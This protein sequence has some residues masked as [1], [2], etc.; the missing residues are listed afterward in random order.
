MKT[1]GWMLLAVL[2]LFSCKRENDKPSGNVK[3][4]I[5]SVW[6]NG[7][8]VT[9]YST[10]YEMDYEGLELRV[11]F[12]SKVDS[13]LFN[14]SKFYFSGE[15]DTLYAYRFLNSC[16]GLVISTQQSL[17]PLYSYR[18]SIEEGKNFGG[19][20]YDPFTCNIVTRLDT[21]PKF[22]SISEDSLLTLV[23]EKTFRYFLDYAHP[24]SGLARE[25]FG[26]GDVVT[27]GGSGF[28]IMAILVGIERNFISRQQGFDQIR[29]VVNFFNNPSTDKFHGAFPHWMNG[30][31]GKAIPFSTKD[32]GGDLV[33]TAFLMQGLLTAKAYFKNGSL[34]E[35][36]VC[37]TIQQLYKNVEWSWYRHDNQNKLY[38]HWSPN[39]NWD[40]N[41]PVSGWNEALI[42]YVLAASSPT[43]AIPK[44]V[45]DEGWAVQGNYPMKNGKTYYNTI[46]PL[47]PDFGGPLFFAHYSFLGLDPRNLSDAY[48]NYWTQNVAHSKINFEYCS[49][50]PKKYYGY[51]SKCW[52]LTA[53]DISNGYSASSP[54]NDLGVI[55]PTAAISSMPYTPVQSKEALKFFYYILGDKLWG[56]Y[57]FYDAFSLSSRWFASSYLAIDQ[58]PIICMIENYRTGLLWNLFM[59][60]P[61]IKE[62]LNKLGFMY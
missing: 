39:Y 6:V 43:Y 10:I 56:Q 11:K 45:Y 38:W 58:G 30:N 24:I 60:N 50:N 37:D 32:N 42:V 49:V 21:T 19:T 29:K 3:I 27:T 20:I 8:S 47:G 35:K 54:T 14:K 31:T 2:I 44:V 5:D 16:D 41:M 17:K 1:I 9:N 62:G 55:A 51:S 7:I 34:E 18:F 36:A 46:L 53:S 23:Q 40:M 28:G 57:G 61:E 25:R 59:S 22:P 4:T 26:S 15:L 48:A 52:G 13:M 33:E 12:A